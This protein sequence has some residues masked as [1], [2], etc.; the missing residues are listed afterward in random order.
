M[1]QRGERYS[2]YDEAEQ[3]H[4]HYCEQVRDIERTMHWRKAKRYRNRLDAERRRMNNKA[5]RRRMLQ[6]MTDMAK[7]LEANLRS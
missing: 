7:S 3:G 4:L 2:T 1:D 6:Q 5:R